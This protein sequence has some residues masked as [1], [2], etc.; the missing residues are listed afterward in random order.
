MTMTTTS[1]STSSSEPASAASGSSVRVLI[2]EDE[3]HLGIILEQFLLARGF[4]VSIVRDGRTALERLRTEA[5]DVALLDVVM[6][7]LDGLEVLRQ[8]REEPLP[9]E[10]IVITGNGT[11]ETAIA[12]LKLGAYD[13]L[14][15][16]YRMAEIEVLVR[17]AWEKRMLARDNVVLRSQ[18]D[19]QA[20][21]PV[22]L[23]QFAPL[24]AIRHMLTKVA[25]STSPVLITG[26]SG[27][28]KDLVARLLHAEGGRPSGPFIAINCAGLEESRLELELFGVERGAY[29]GA[30]QRKLGLFEL[31]AGGTLYLDN[32]GD[33][34]LK[35]QGK[36]L[37]A[38]ETGSFFRVGGTQQVAVDVRVVASTTRDLS[39]M[40]QAETFRDDLLHRINTIRIALPPLRDRATDIAPLARHFLELFTPRGDT[41]RGDAPRAEEG[42]AALRLSDDAVAALER[43]RWPGNVREL[44]NVMERAALLATHET[45]QAGDLPLGIDV[46]A[47]ARPTPAQGAARI[48]EPATMPASAPQASEVLSLGELEKRHIHDVLERTHWHQGRAADLLGISPKTLYRKIR[49]FG[50]ARP[51]G[52]SI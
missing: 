7:E 15:K 36:L 20:P 44:R 14:S 51:G 33:L 31:A 9:P 16:P 43:Y 29:P 6:P 52:R 48:P 46:G 4:R 24:L 10:I 12:A 27:T 37:R 34:D 3:T 41:P 5:F 47:A 21:V 18:L 42:R 28:G 38:L 40:V 50:F 22:F 19:R 11:I 39:R 26:E 17:R 30:E 25:A 49:E 32:V 2:A 45:V 23:T 35:L 1:T 13:F 8:V